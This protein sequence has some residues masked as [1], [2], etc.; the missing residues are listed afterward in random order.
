MSDMDGIDHMFNDL[1]GELDHL[2]Q[3]IAAASQTPDNDP[4]SEN[5]ISVG[6][7]DL[8]AESLNELE[9]ND[10][11]DLVADL[12]LKEPQL[13]PSTCGH[14]LNHDETPFRNE[15]PE[16]AAVLPPPPTT[17]PL[18]KEK[19]E[20]QTK[21]DKIKLALEKLKEAKVKKMIVKVLLCDGSS[22]ILMVDER[23]KVQDVL[24][25]LLE[26]THCDGSIDWSLCETNPELQ[27]DRILEDNENLVEMLSLWTRHTD[28]KICFMLRPEKYVMFTEPQLFYMW[29]K[30]EWPSSGVNQQAKKLLLKEN[31]EGCAV[32]VPD[33]DGMLY[34]KEDGKKVWK[35]RHFVLRA[36]GIYFIPNGKT[37]S[38]IDLACFTRFENV[39][40]YIAHKYKQKYKAPTNFC[41]ILKHPCIQKESHYIKFLCCDEKH[42][43]LLWVNSIRI[44]KYGA[45]LHKSYK[46][47]LKRASLQQFSHI[48][49][50][51]SRVETS[52]QIV[53]N[54][55]D[56]PY[57]EPP[58]FIPPPPPLGSSDV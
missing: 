20:S 41:F 4:Q 5:T 3:I 46:D 19:H 28:N 39:N 25:K 44:A 1:I 8:N 32:I 30:K 38:S 18:S 45:A 42:S 7:T 48:S 52:P 15:E 40:I 57:E 58:D 10:L 37:K 24:N 13:E 43:L 17:P 47:A 55:E 50:G 6:F 53:T 16:S 31:F 26:K 21:A 36:S 33:L 23:Q 11:D 27:I 29:K 2:S 56:Y 22:K 12:E 14:D 51:V 34:L 49:A 9:D 35:P 54:V